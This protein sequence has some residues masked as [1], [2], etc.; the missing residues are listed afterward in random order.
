LEIVPLSGR[1]AIL[2][3]DIGSPLGNGNFPHAPHRFHGGQI[4]A[5]A[6]KA[7]DVENRAGGIDL[8]IAGREFG[9]QRCPSANDQ[10]KGKDANRNRE[11][12]QEG[13]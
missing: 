5:I 13:A 11:D 12:D 2:D 10:P 9:A 1:V 6:V 7:I 3:D 8:L 4:K